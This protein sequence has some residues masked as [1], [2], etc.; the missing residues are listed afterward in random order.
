[1]SPNAN[2]LTGVFGPYFLL[3]SEFHVPKTLP[4]APRRFD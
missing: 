2:R 4:Q 3:V 1:M